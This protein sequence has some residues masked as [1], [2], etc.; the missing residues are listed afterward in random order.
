MEYVDRMLTY[1]FRSG[2][3][4][5][6]R[7]LLLEEA[8]LCV[9]PRPH[10]YSKARAA[11]QKSAC[12]L[13]RI[14]QVAWPRTIGRHIVIPKEEVGRVFLSAAISPGLSRSDFPELP[15]VVG[16]ALPSL[17][18]NPLLPYALKHLGFACVDPKHSA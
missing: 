5:P 6:P 17:G 2:P 7:F 15:A 9:S 14:V 16:E 10:A 1:L 11:L 12:S 13:M 8:G 3:R 4:D 18:V